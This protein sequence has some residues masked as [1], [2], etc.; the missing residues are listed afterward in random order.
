MRR[1][2]AD[3]A[4]PGSAAGCAVR[5]LRRAAGQWQ[6][7]PGRAHVVI[8]MARKSCAAACDIVA[9]TSG[10]GG[11]VQVQLVELSRC[12]IKFLSTPP[13]TPLTNC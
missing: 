4:H 2:V 11:L 13:P 12:L 7:Q 3:D 5:V 8:L 1:V 10:G 6:L 9:R